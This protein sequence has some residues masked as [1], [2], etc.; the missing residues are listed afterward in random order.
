MDTAFRHIFVP[1]ASV[2]ST[3]REKRNLFLNCK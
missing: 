3:N 2:C 1:S